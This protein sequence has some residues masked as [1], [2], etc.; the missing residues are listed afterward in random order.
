MA[1]TTLGTIP[2]DLS[3]RPLKTGITGFEKL[4]ILR[5][6]Q[7]DLVVVAARPGHGKSL[8]ATQISLQ[9]PGLVVFESLEMSKEVFELRALC[10]E[11]KVGSQE[12]EY[13]EPKALQTGKDR[14]ASREV[15]IAD[16]PQPIETM[17][18]EIR[19]LA[20]QTKPELIVIDYAQIITTITWFSRIQEKIGYC[21]K[22]LKHL[23]NEIKTPILLL[24]QMNRS[25]EMRLTENPMAQPVMADIADAADIERWADAVA[26]L[27]K[28]SPEQ[29]DVYV[30][31]NRHGELKDFSLD[32][33]GSQFR[34]VNQ[35][36]GL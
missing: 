21:M 6:N 10:F 14:L 11:L 23:A 32:F 13:L 5:R 22:H 27:H 29:I 35:V 26:V 28:K 2:V 19:Q 8:M 3:I 16:T 24:A 25:F 12:L 33:I 9:T 15:I 4:S 36:G 17:V 7:G 31:K 30:L 18:D 34:L 20:K 1:F